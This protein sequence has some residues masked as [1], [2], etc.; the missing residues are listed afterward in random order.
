MNAAEVTHG[1]KM[2][3]G[4]TRMWVGVLV[5]ALMFV[6]IANY[7]EREQHRNF[8]MQVRY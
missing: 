4:N 3:G 7:V 1:L 5:V 6:L 8:R 2:L